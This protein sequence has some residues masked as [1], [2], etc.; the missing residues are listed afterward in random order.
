MALRAISSE[1]ITVADSS[2]G[3]TT[4]EVAATTGVTRAVCRVEEQ[5]IRIQTDGTDPAA[6]SGGLEQAAGDEFVIEGYDDLQKF[7]AIRTGG[8]SGIIEVIYEG[9]P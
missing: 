1:R 8:S 4:S 6:G 5:E 2:I 9:Y 3:F 7:R